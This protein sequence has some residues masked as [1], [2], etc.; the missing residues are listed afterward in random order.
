MQLRVLR[1]PWLLVL[2]FGAL[3]ANA[4]AP[5]QAPTT[6]A[7]AR[8]D[9]LPK[10]R[11]LRPTTRIGELVEFELTFRHEPALNVVF[12]DSTAEYKP[13]EYV[14]REYWPTRTS[15]G[16]S[17]D[18]CRYTLRTFSLDSLQQLQLPVTVLRGRDTVLLYAAPAA[19]RLVRTAPAVASGADLPPLR[20][21][22]R[23]APVEPLFNY[24]YWIA[25]ALAVLAVAGVIW[26]TF[27]RNLRQRYR[28][29]RMARNHVYFMAQYARHLERF[30]LSR[31]LANMERA[32][33]LWKNYLARLEGNSLNT[34]TTREI[35][36]QYQGDS[37][38]ATALRL[39]DRMIYGN[40]LPDEAAEQTDHALEL[41][42]R[43]ADRRYQL[44]RTAS[45][46]RQAIGS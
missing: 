35:V 45:L 20:Q 1:W 13:F 17:L 12:P 41:L 44:V 46:R 39:S 31:S 30:Q 42:R 21:D 3:G 25:G 32:I 40:Q 33:T 23:P 28:R 16:V 8:P 2:L 34:L 38:V 27:G 4:Q 37:D 22:L 5:A 29:Y 18:R 7:A 24:P 15:N 10:G 11:F 14:R 43:F 19:V 36:A 26:W 6:P 9:S